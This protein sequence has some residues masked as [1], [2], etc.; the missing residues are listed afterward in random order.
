MADIVIFY[1]LPERELN[2]ANLL[3]A[4]FEKRGYSVDI[5]GYYNYRELIFPKEYKPKLLIGQ[6]G[7]NNNDI[8]RYTVRFKPK[9]DKILNLRYEQV[10]AK[11]I[12]DS[13]AHYPKEYMKKASHVCWSEKIK[14]DMMAEGIDEKNLPV[15]GDI[16]TD[17]SNHRF[18]SFFKT[19]DQLASEFNLDSSKEW[20]LFISSFTFNEKDSKRLM[21]M[22]HNLDDGKYMQ[23]WNV[24]S[25]AI[26]MEWFE[27]FLKAH[28][29]KEF[30]YRPH[31]VEFNVLDEDSTISILDEKYL[32]FHY[33]NKYAIQEWIR[34]CDYLNTV[35]STSII[36]VYLLEKQCN[37]LR[38][39]ELNPDFDNPLL[40][41][42]KTICTYDEFEKLNT[43]KNTD[44]F[45]VSREMIGQYYDFGDKLAYERICD[46]AEKMINDDSFKQDF[47][48][49]PSRFHRLKFII[50]RSLDVP[51][52]IP[53]VIKSAIK[54]KSSTSKTKDNRSIYEKNAKKIREI[55]NQ[56]S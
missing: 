6:A 30:I 23:K 12:L 52:L 31:P 11:R 27:K 41:G 33:I 51:K 25:K 42:A 16:K 13:K 39:V 20:I 14:Q 29:E 32:N 17:F 4:E 37:I 15:T 35:I 2:N 28:P 43:D 47:Y 45:P 18:D 36:D 40:V 24:E 46:Y 55:V 19:K 8:E 44:E 48:P 5:L 21:S 56:S 49:N 53:A 34:P 10:I 22:N 3:K 1:E 9:I 50:K 26:V 54:N 38:P 7:Y